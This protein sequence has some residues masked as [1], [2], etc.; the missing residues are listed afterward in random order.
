M[1]QLTARIFT[2]LLAVVLWTAGT[3][4][5]Q[6]PAVI[7][8]NIP[9]EFSLGNK[10]FPP[11][12]YSLVQPLQHF[13]VLRDARGQ[14][15]ASTFTS[16]IESSAASATSKL[17]FNFVAG[18]NVL[19]EVW[20]QND[21]SGVKVYPTNTSSRGYLAKRRSPEARQTAEGSQP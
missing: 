8:V 14:T 1:K 16:G 15:I 4:Y 18:R 21:S 19:T 12:D 10:T 20:Q 7:R 5:A 9:F 2:S 3:A 17:R 6:T 11:G 13:L